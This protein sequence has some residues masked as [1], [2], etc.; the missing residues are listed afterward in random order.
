MDIKGNFISY[1]F[2]FPLLHFTS[3]FVSRYEKRE[4]AFKENFKK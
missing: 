4:M 2:L 1:F 3:R